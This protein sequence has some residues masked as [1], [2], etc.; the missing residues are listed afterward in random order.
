MNRKNPFIHRW[1]RFTQMKAPVE[2]GHHTIVKPGDRNASLF[3]SVFICAIC[4]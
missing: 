1:H 3:L 2:M 4:G